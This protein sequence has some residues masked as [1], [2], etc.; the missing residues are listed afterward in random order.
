LP[1]GRDQMDDIAFGQGMED[2][3]MAAIG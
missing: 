2:Y 1:D 3:H